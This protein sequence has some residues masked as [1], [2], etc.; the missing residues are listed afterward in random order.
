MTTEDLLRLV[1][2]LSR[3]QVDFTTL[4]WTVN[5]TMKDADELLSVAGTGV[6]LRASYVPT[7]KNRDLYPFPAGLVRPAS[8]ERLDRESYWELQL[9]PAS[10]IPRQHQA[11]RGSGFCSIVGESLRVRPIPDEDNEKGLRVWGYY[12]H[13]IQVGGSIDT[14]VVFPAHAEQYVVWRSAAAL[15]ED[16][17]AKARCEEEA[18]RAKLTFQKLVEIPHAGVGAQI[19]REVP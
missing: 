11:M 10:L 17:N 2:Q 12:A 14:E 15:A 3:A 5:A 13:T 7:E 6:G 18:S 9:I 19:I 1:A 4:A 16:K 8:V